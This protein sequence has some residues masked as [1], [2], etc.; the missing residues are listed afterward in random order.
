MLL[1]HVIIYIQDKSCVL[2]I[3]IHLTE[4]ICIIVNNLILI[5]DVVWY[6]SYVGTKGGLMEIGNCQI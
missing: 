6:G 4:D 3:D 2:I 5:Y 1:I